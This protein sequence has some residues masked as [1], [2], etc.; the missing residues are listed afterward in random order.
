MFKN[1]IIEAL[2][3][4]DELV[5]TGK[6]TLPKNFHISEREARDLLLENMGEVELFETP[7]EDIII[8]IIEEMG[9]EFK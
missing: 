6:T 3:Q 2:L 8:L 9:G 7:I 4:I 5:E 1:K